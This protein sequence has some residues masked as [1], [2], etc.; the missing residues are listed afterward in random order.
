MIKIR[1]KIFTVLPANSSPTQGTSTAR[2]ITDSDKAH[3][4]GITELIRKRQ[5]PVV[6]IKELEWR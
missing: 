4:K 1:R 6:K 2:P 3:L 5:V